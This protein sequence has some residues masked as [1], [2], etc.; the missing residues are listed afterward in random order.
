MARARSCSPPPAWRARRSAIT[1]TVAS[2]GGTFSIEINTGS[3]AVNAKID[4][5]HTVAQPAGP[6]LK[7]TGMGVTLT[8]PGAIAL[9][10]DFGLEQVT[11]GNLRSSASP[12]R[13]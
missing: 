12:R 1:S 4:D 13:T 8:L 10:G 9:K 5:T 7:V 11:I 6:Y 2:F 3:A